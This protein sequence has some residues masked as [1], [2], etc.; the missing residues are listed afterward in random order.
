MLGGA[1]GKRLRRERRIASAA[2]AHY[3]RA[4][5]AEVGHLV[6]KAEAI[7]DVG[8]LVVAHA[9]A[10]V[11]VRRYAHRAANRRTLNGDRAR[12]SI[13]LLHLVLREGGDLPLVVL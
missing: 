8:F 4:E 11:R 3:R 10:A 9:R 7:D 13:P 2:R 5:H 6:R 12:F 1:P